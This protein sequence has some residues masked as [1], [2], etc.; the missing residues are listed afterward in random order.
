MRL[1]LGKGLYVDSNMVWKR[2]IWAGESWILRIEMKSLKERCA[3][4]IRSSDILILVTDLGRIQGMYGMVLTSFISWETC[5]PFSIIKSIWP[6][7]LF[8]PDLCISGE[9]QVHNFRDCERRLEKITSRRQPISTIF[10]TSTFVSMKNYV[11]SVT[12]PSIVVESRVL[13]EC[14][15]PWRQDWFQHRL[16]CSFQT[17]KIRSYDGDMTIL[18]AIHGRKYWVLRSKVDHGWYGNCLWCPVSN[19]PCLVMNCPFRNKYYPDVF[20]FEDSDCRRLL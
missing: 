11:A 19:E 18:M 17:E 15:K 16:T 14:P 1:A 13:E 8:L 20:D 7:C 3:V 12:S 5:S 6:G 2:R 9:C 4:E 10:V